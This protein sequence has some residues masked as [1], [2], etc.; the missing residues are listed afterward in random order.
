MLGLFKKTITPEDFGGIVIR[1]ASEIILK[2][3]ANSLG[4]LFDDFFDR[5]TSLTAVEYL[6]RHG[7]P[8]PKTN[9]YIR[10]FVHCAVQAGS[11]QFD[12][13]AGRAMTLGAMKS[14]QKTPEGYDFAT[15]YNAFDAVYRGRHKF[16]PRIEPLNNPKYQWPFLPNPNAGVLN[17]KY[18]IENFVISNVN[19]ERV[20]SDGF[21]L[22]SGTV[23]G[24][25]NIVLRAMAEISKSVK[26]T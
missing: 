3:A 20:L 18:M 7:I 15:I 14:F 10:L 16:E 8:A 1:W 19:N 17:A 22:Y 6:E 26:L 21:E 12:Q 13:Q 5:D 2:D 11:T 25:L 23:C 9:L 24:A 4:R